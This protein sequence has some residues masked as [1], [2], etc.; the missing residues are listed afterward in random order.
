MSNFPTRRENNL[1]WTTFFVLFLRKK[2]KWDKMERLSRYR[3]VNR[4]LTRRLSCVSRPSSLLI[5]NHDRLRTQ[6]REAGFLAGVGKGWNLY[7][8]FQGQNSNSEFT[9][10]KS[11]KLPLDSW[12][13]V[14]YWVPVD[15]ISIK[16]LT[17]G[18]GRLGVLSRKRSNTVKY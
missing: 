3:L 4:G 8:R 14:E 18:I 9:T 13:L 12:L 15:F 6:R 16:R 5:V 2:R 1:E 11:A 7:R 10:E 17:S